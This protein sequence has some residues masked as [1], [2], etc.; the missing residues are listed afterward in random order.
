MP[1]FR[2][3]DDL[4]KSLWAGGLADETP[5]IVAT[6]RPAV[7]FARQQISDSALAVATSKLGSDPDLPPGFLW[8]Q[9]PPL[10]DADQQAAT[11]RKLG[12]IVRGHVGNGGDAKKHQSIEDKK[13]AW[14]FRPFPLAFVAQ[15]NLAQIASTVGLPPEMPQTGMLSVFQ[16]VLGNDIALPWHDGPTDQLRRCASPQEII[17]YAGQC[18]RDADDPSFDWHE[19]AMAELLHPFAAIMV[20]H[21]WKRAFPQG[22]AKWQRIWDW[23]MDHE[24]GFSPGD[25]DL[26]PR[27]PAS[28]DAPI[29]NFGDS[30]GG[31]PSCIQGDDEEEL[32]GEP[33]K[34]PGLTPWRHVFSFAAE[35]CAET[36]RLNPDWAGDG[37]TFVMLRETDLVFRR[38]DA[39]RGVYQQT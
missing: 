36:R 3:T 11:M 22:S 4:A 19:W 25:G 21:H 2:N 18:S 13:V 12:E 9:R 20:P 35:Y 38:F 10:P 16:D 31:W 6:A 26:T 24:F 28:A 27:Q 17:E 8:P 29:A 1:T 30:L 7:L 5:A 14:L 23:F 34:A 33:V 32:T 39:A 37:N 15:L